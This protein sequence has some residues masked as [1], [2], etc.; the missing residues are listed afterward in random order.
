MVGPGRVIEYELHH[1]LRWT[2]L[3]TLL[4]QQTALD[5]LLGWLEVL[6]AL[7]LLLKGFWVLFFF[8]FKIVDENNNLKYT[9]TYEEIRREGYKC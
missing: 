5:G 1:S 6:P 9:K 2:S 3:P 7:L 8:I 4:E